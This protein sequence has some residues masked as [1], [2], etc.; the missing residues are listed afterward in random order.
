MPQGRTLGLARPGRDAMT[1]TARGR[2]DG[3]AWPLVTGS[4]ELESLLTE[5][6]AASGPDRDRVKQIFKALSPQRGPSSSPHHEGAGYLMVILFANA[7]RLST[8]A[9]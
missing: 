6:V 4:R 3:R 1:V 5:S 2:W 7:S 9:T 8:G